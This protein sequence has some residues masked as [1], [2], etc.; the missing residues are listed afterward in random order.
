MPDQNVV[1]YDYFQRGSRPTRRG[2]PRGRPAG[3]TRGRGRAQA[4][5][6]AY[7]DVTPSAGEGSGTWKMVARFVCSIPGCDASFSKKHNLLRHQTQKHGRQKST[8]TGYDA[9]DGDGGGEG[10][11]G[12]YYD[13]DDCEDGEFY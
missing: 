11:F 8:R 2:T 13:E 9:R 3:T 7:S 10:E 6:P 5:T 1:S 4:N 12:D